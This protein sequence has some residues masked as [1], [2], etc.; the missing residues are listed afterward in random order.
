VKWVGRNEKEK[1]WEHHSS[2][3]PNLVAA[4]ERAARGKSVIEKVL[5]SGKVG[6]WPSAS[7]GDDQFMV[8]DSHNQHRWVDRD[9][10]PLLVLNLWEAT[11]ASEE[12]RKRESE[13]FHWCKAGWCNRHGPSSDFVSARAKYTGSNQSIKAKK[14]QLWR[15]F[16]LSMRRQDVVDGLSEAP[17]GSSWKVCK[18]HFADVENR[19]WHKLCDD[20]V[21]NRRAPGIRLDEVQSSV[22]V[23]E[24]LAAT[25]RHGTDFGASATPLT[26]PGASADRQYRFDVRNA[27]KEGM[28]TVTATKTSPEARKPSRSAITPAPSTEANIAKINQAVLLNQSAQT[29]IARLK[30]E[31]T[32]MKHEA[33]RRSTLTVECLSYESIINS[34]EIPDLSGKFISLPAKGAAAMV[35]AAEAIGLDHAWR[36]A[37]A[38]ECRLAH[39]S[40]SRAL[41]FGFRNSVM[42]VLAKCKLATSL[43]VL[44]WAF[45]L[46]PSQALLAG[47]LFKVT[48]MILNGLLSRTVARI[49]DICQVDHD[50][51]PDLRHPMFSDVGLTADA[52]NIVTQKSH[53]PYGLKHSHSKYYGSNC[54][55]FSV[56]I[57]NDG[58]PLWVSFSF[59]GR[60]SECGIMTESN[61]E[62][63]Y[64]E[65]KGACIDDE[66]KPFDPAVMADK[67]T[68][69]H[70]MMR[71]LGGDYI[72]PSSLVDRDLTAQDLEEN[73]L[74]A[75]ARGHVERAIG[76]AKRFRILTTPMHHR[77]LPV[78]DDILFFCIFATH[79][80]GE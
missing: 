35:E 57:S 33:E 79:F 22:F 41:R 56:A 23:S 70:D 10:V 49:P 77:L 75:K 16:Y 17:V 65:F 63:W 4:F 69:I 9:E 20:P 28:V 37:I 51:L 26:E 27:V 80:L 38:D 39:V 12:A 43:S 62:D 61:F 76:R 58:L 21:F 44:A 45:G 18:I 47:T 71:S 7:K 25:E 64:R 54:G 13:K 34:E 32:Q 68:N 3:P 52:S 31:L 8:L 74:I 53:N 36:D 55:K 67:G 48:L 66:G 29:E 19:V 14:D 1:D 2:L 5:R 15:S 50:T 30:R 59:G 6:G 72:T 46:G 60:G 11:Q 78:I 24:R 42:L 40:T 73:E